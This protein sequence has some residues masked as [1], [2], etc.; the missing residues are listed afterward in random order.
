M[1]SL[2]AVTVTASSAAGTARTSGGFATE[3]AFSRTFDDWE[4]AVAADAFG[5]VYQITTR[6]GAKP[7]CRTC[8]QHFLVYRVSD[9]RG[10]TWGHDRYLCRCPGFTGQND[11]EVVTDAG[12]RVFVA[13]LNDFRVSFQR[14][15]DFGQTW[16]HYRTVDGNL[17][18]SD[19]PT[20]AVSNSGRD[21]YIVFN[22]NHT[23]P[24]TGLPFA[25]ASHDAGVSWTDPVLAFRS[26]RYFFSGGSTV[27][28]DG[29]VFAAQDAY[30]QDSVGDILLSVLSSS[31]GGRSWTNTLV[32]RSAQQRSCPGWAGCAEPYFG[33]QATIASDAAGR[34]YVLYNANEVDEGPARVWIT[35]SE[36][37]GS[38]WSPPVDV[39][40]ASLDVDHEFTMIAATG[41]GDVR[42]AWMDD[43]TGAWNTWYRRSTDGGLTW[44]E[45]VRLSNRANGAHYKRAEGF[46]FPYGD[47]GQLAIDDAGG[48]QAIWGEGPT[49]IGPGGSWFTRETV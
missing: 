9:D 49:Y 8:P 20:I 22:G 21:V 23:P 41:D 5:H 11:P 18:Y 37:G 4:P 14:S 44:S 45:E 17:G 35:V 39:S 10:V 29:S 12:G 2:I 28:P 42:V 19:K 25:A 40:S 16:T 7:A 6:Y 36:D 26:H 1:I 33:A 31:D 15:D 13:W 27:L 48:T 43:R 30:H 38:T 3:R 47:Y 34:L 32:G 24:A 46:R